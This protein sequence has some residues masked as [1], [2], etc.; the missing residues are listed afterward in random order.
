[1]ITS[2]GSLGFDHYFYSSSNIVKKVKKAME[3]LSDTK[4]AYQGL[5]DSS[6][7]K[8]FRTGSGR[9]N[10]PRDT[11][12]MLSRSM[13]SNKK[14]VLESLSLGLMIW[15]L[16]LNINASYQPGD[17][18]RLEALSFSFSVSFSLISACDGSCIRGSA[19]KS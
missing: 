13:K 12:G 9:R 14:K 10:R 4:A 3:G 6:P 16:N 5:T 19:S 11:E 1:V 7:K 15:M 18:A 17:A 8:N 2:I